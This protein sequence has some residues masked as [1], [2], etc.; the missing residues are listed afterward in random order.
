MYCLISI[1]LQIVWTSST[2]IL[3]AV[4][5]KS[6]IIVDSIEIFPVE[7]VVRGWVDFFFC[8]KKLHFLAELN[9][10][11]TPLMTNTSQCTNYISLHI[12]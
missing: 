6:K 11:K 3:E 7:D 9:Q 12:T 8:E 10:F 5:I 4:Q 1:Q 2:F